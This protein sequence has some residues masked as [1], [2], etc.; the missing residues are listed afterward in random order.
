MSGFPYRPPVLG[1][2][3][4]VGC[5]QYKENLSAFK[6]FVSPEAVN[7]FRFGMV[8]KFG[9]ARLYDTSPSVTPQERVNLEMMKAIE[10][11][12]RRLERTENQRDQL[13]ERLALIESS[14]TIDEKTG[15]LYLPV[16]MEPGTPV[17]G[18]SAPG[19][20]VGIS[21]MSSVLAV[22]ALGLSLYREPAE[23]SLT[24]RQLAA[25]NALAEPMQ[26]VSRENRWKKVDESE[27][28]DLREE[29]AARAPVT[30][31]AP[32]APETV[33]T[34]EANTHLWPDV[35]GP[36]KPPSAEATEGWRV[37]EAPKKIPPA[38]RQPVAETAVADTA[39]T[40]EA[41]P[42]PAAEAPKPDV[43]TAEAP[44]PLVIRPE[45]AV[46]ETEPPKPAGGPD[47]K[48][49]SIEIGPDPALPPKLAELEKRAFSG[50]PEAQHDLAIIYASGKAVAQDYKRAAYWFYKAADGGIANAD[51]NLGV[52]F[53]QGMG[54]KKDVNKALGWYEKAAQLDHPEAMYNLGIAYV[55]GVG[56]LR[57]ID[58]GVSFF[59]K[60]ANAGVAQA[61]YNLGVLYESNFVGPINLTK[62]SEWYQ[63]A[64][65]Q[66]HATAKEAVARL[67]QQ[68]AEAEKTAEQTAQAAATVEPATGTKE[69]KTGQGDSPPAS[70]GNHDLVIKLQ[71]VLI[72]R[73][74]ISGSASG[75][76]DERT[77]DA[78]RAWQK[79]LGF[80]ETGLPT[81]ELVEGIRA[82][83]AQK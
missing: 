6:A 34:A 59:K 74:D 51:Y 9:T 21:L 39:V 29:A 47:E 48:A 35:F 49:A 28:L 30:E 77:V 18:S 36:P 4:L 24:P 43:K 19:W 50:A 37:A 23:P 12:G 44:V 71:S 2:E 20:A 38:E 41:L 75:M 80:V 83:S 61:A 70:E 11:I 55:E 10:M 58:R 60:A 63:V 52:M 8:N 42:P 67:H 32:K 82:A 72:A 45:V 53:Q 68:I 57:N 26:F 79:K 15:K 3:N 78:I 65:E 56:T 1:A 69:E 54:V 40:E 33:T 25:L 5:R 64:A 31:P 14:A 22:F 7:A 73:G 16:V 76:L 62:A 27:G 81:P 13:A 46:Q 66:G 17:P